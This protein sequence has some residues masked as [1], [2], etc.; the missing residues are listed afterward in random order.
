[1][2]STTIRE[3]ERTRA[4]SRTRPETAGASLGNHAGFHVLKL[5]ENACAIDGFA[6]AGERAFPGCRG[7]GEALLLVAQ[8]AQVILNDG[9]L[10]QL[11]GRFG[12][13]W[14]GEIELAL[15]E[16]RPPQAI[17]ERGVARFELERSLD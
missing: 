8:I 16:V 11:R 17:E 6:I 13:R 10:G 2:A 9:T 7:I 4:S 14:I 3:R 5:L 12:Q 15:L 1:M